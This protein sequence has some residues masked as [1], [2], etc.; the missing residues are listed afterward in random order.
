VTVV[1]LAQV[2]NIPL[3][4]EQQA[5]VVVLAVLTAI[6]AAVCRAVRFRFWLSS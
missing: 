4:L 2:F 5:I 1:F 3:T 6:G